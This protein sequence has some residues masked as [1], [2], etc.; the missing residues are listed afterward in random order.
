MDTP[1]TVPYGWSMRTAIVASVV[2]GLVGIVVAGGPPPGPP[3][4]G[5][6]TADAHVCNM[7]DTLQAEGGGPE[8]QYQGRTYHFCCEGCASSF[9]ADP[10]KYAFTKDPVSGAEVDK[11]KALMFAVKNHVYYFVSAKTRDAFAKDPAKYVKG[12]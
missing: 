10:K 2:L 4:T 7:Q 5:P 1:A 3:F 12:S 11:A 6:L 8:R 9:D